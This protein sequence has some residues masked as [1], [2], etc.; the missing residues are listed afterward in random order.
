MLAARLDHGHLHVERAEDRGVLDADDAGADH[1]QMARQALEIED[2]VAVEDAV[3]VE[4]HVRRGGRAGCRR[5]ARSGRRCRRM[6]LA[7]IACDLDLLRVERS[8]P[9]RAGSSTPLRANW[10]SSTSTSWSRV[11]CRRLQQVVGG[12]VLLDPVGAAVEAALAPAGEVEHGLAQG[13]A[14]GSCRC[15]PRRRRRGGRARP[16]APSLLSL[17]AW[18]AARRP[19]GPL[20][21]TIRS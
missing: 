15:A 4:R 10:C 7:A 8:A 6:R 16:P 14:T 17:A 20:P 9:R 19:A 13:L 21:M 12:D 2:L 1:R 5:R 18:I 3:A 11:M